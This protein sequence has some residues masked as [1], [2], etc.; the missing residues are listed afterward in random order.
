MPRTCHAL[1]LSEVVW[2]FQSPGSRLFL[3]LIEKERMQKS[4]IKQLDDVSNTQLSKNQTVK[5]TQ[6]EQ[7]QTPQNNP[8]VT[9]VINILKKYESRTI[10]LAAT[11]IIRRL[12]FFPPSTNFCSV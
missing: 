4:D 5:E 3:S 1:L 2:V 10:V 12:T 11:Y 9:E 7:K 8:E 6:I